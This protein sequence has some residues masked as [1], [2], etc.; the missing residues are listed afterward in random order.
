MNAMH[1]SVFLVFVASKPGI[2][3][4]FIIESCVILI[5]VH[6]SARVETKINQPKKQKREMP[7]IHQYV[8]L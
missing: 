8:I 5:T 4:Y 2:L 3:R 1:T 6:G 7:M